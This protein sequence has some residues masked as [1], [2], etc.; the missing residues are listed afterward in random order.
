MPGVKSFVKRTAATVDRVI[1]PPP[2]VTILIYH[3]V[4]GGSDSEVDL[5]TDE[6][7]RQLEHLAEH[8]RVISLDEAVDELSAGSINGWS[9]APVGDAP[10]TPVEARSRLSR[11][12]T[13]GVPS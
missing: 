7:E 1:P 10:T 12:S 8:H 11:L 6:F 2:G 4:G 9:A 5:P 13:R 3:R